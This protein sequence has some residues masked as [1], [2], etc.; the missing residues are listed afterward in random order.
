MST[1]H[2]RAVQQEKVH[3]AVVGWLTH[4]RP[5]SRSG[6]PLTASE[7]AMV[8][9]HV[10]QRVPNCDGSPR[11][12]MTTPVQEAIQRALEAHNRTVDGIDLMQATRRKMGFDARSDW[13][14]ERY[15]D[16]IPAGL[17]CLGWSGGLY[18][19]DE[20]LSILGELMQNLIA[21]DRK[22][23]QAEGEYAE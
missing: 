8:Y 4:V 23:Q 11:Y 3:A 1:K 13:R 19:S 16:S 21:A 12:V 17:R 14:F 10:R 7:K 20:E 2:Y 9:E 22:R 5:R 6:F 15:W 18:S